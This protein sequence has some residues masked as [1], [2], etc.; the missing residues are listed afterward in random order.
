MSREVRRVPPDWE[1]PR[2][3]NGF[4]YYGHTEVALQPMFDESYRAAKERYDAGL[5]RWKQGEDPGQQR[6]GLPKTEAEYR[7]YHGGPGDRNYY[8]PDWPEESR[9][10]YQVYETVTEGTPISPVFADREDL[11]A[12]LGQPQ[13]L[14]G[15]GRPVAMDRAQA[16]RFIEHGSVGSMVWTAETGLISGSE[17]V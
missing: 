11:I 4:R 16:E 5:L 14:M 1:H 10:A 13:A 15:I 3:K 8:R 6:R 9:T 17:A 7:D 12:W 2:M